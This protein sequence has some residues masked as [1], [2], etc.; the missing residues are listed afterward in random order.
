VLLLRLTSYLSQSR[1][2]LLSVNGAYIQ[3]V[4]REIFLFIV[5]DVEETESAGKQESRSRPREKENT[6]KRKRQESKWSI[7]QRKLLRNSGK[8]YQNSRG[9]NI[10][11]REVKERTCKCKLDCKTI[12]E[13]DRK[14]IFQN[15]WGMASYARQRD[16]IVQHI[17]QTDCA[18]HKTVILGRKRQKSNSYFFDL[19]NVKVK[20]CK[21]FFCKTLDIGR[22]TVGVALEKKLPGCTNISP[23]KRGKMRGSKGIKYVNVIK[24]HINSYPVMHP[25]YV[26]KSSKRKYLDRT[27]NIS[28]MHSQFLELYKDSDPELANTKLS[29]Y[30]YVFNTEFNLSFFRPKKD[31]CLKCTQF[32]DLKCPSDQDKITY[33]QHIELKEQAQR[34]KAHDKNRSLIDPE[35]F[36]FTFDLQSV[37]YTPCSAVSSL[38]YTRKLSVYNLTIYNQTSKDGWCFMWDECNGQ[39]GSCEIGTCIHK[40]IE[41]LPKTCRNVSFY[42]DSCGGQNRNQFL[43]GAVLYSLNHSSLETVSV[44][45]LVS[46]HT[47]MECDSMHSAIESSKKYGQKVNIPDD[48]HNIIRAARK[49]QPY[50]IVPLEYSDF[51]DFK[52]YCRALNMKIDETGKPVKWLKLRQ[53]EFRKNSPNKMFIKYNF[54]D[55]YTIVHIKREKKNRN[56]APVKDVQ[57]EQKYHSLRPISQAKKQDLVRLCQTGA[58][59]AT[60]LPFYQALPSDLSINDRLP[61]PDVEEEDVDSEVDL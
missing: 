3:K 36:S 47:E 12:S 41:S 23:D 20:V 4:S 50:V 45:Y 19:N 44:K 7:P 46:G 55:P 2:C 54:A 14:K 43:T 49:R 17:E 9:Q 48:W 8:G 56:K 15:Y 61:E 24:N 39:R 27:L 6:R 60:Y 37:L 53:V 29:T 26:R 51:L 33:K 10:R 22:G 28:K 57:V 16:F 35:Y 18:S 13:D 32:K 1:V 21:D 40:L 38:Y 52:P 30:R 5:P 34:E 11:A 42:C 31:Q 59:S 25:H 58:V